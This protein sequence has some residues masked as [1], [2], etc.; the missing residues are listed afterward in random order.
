RLRHSIFVT[1]VR[2]VKPNMKNLLLSLSLLV[3]Q[4]ALGEGMDEL[5]QKLE[6]KQ[7]E[8]WAFN[9]EFYE[10]IHGKVNPDVWPNYSSLNIAERYV[11]LILD[12]E[13]QVNNGG[14]DQ[15]YFNSYGDNAAEAVMALRA[16]GA[17]SVA[18]M[19]VESFSVFPNSKPS[20]DRWVRQAQ[21]EK[22]GESG[23]EK[24][25]KLDD[26]FYEYPDNINALLSAYIISNRAQFE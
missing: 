14:F 3:S 5:I 17:N 7:I 20:P 1:C 8:E 24:L 16:I 13:G 12:L 15:Y 26:Q 22:I 9:Y 6:N 25:S 21:L 2:G 23:N 10:K 11:A 4:F 19:L 18:K